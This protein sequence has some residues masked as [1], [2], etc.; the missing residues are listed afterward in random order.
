MSQNAHKGFTGYRRKK[1]TRFSVRIADLFARRLIA[2]G[3]VGTIAAVC[4]VCVFLIYVVLPLFETPEVDAASQQAMPEVETVR[5]LMVDEY[6]TMGVRLDAAGRVDLFRLDTGK[7]LDSRDISDGT[8]ATSWS[9]SVDGERLIFGYANGTIRLGEM[10]FIA[11][12]LPEDQ[13]PSTAKKLAPGEVAAGPEGSLITLTPGGYRKHSFRLSLEEPISVSDSAIVAVD[14][15]VGSSGVIFAAL[16]S[17][18][19]VFVKS[20]RRFE[21]LMT[22]EVQTELSGGEFDVQE[23]EA[24]GAPGYL[25]LSGA[26]D[27]VY[28]AWQNGRLHRYDTR[29]LDAPQLAEKIDLLAEPGRTVTNLR[30][31]LGRSTMLVGDSAGDLHAFFRI[32][33]EQS[34]AIPDG[35][36]MVRAHHVPGSGAA[37]SSLACSP[38]TRLAMVGYADGQAALLHVTTNQVLT[39]VTAGSGLPVTSM[40]IAPKENALYASCGDRLWG[41][42][43]DVKHPEA[44]LASMFSPIWYEGMPGPE[45]IWQ[46]SSGDDAF[47]PKL[48]LMPLVFG[49]LKATVYSMLFGVPLALLAAVYSSEFMHPR[50]RGRVKPTIELMAS[51]PSVVLGFL[52]ALVIAPFV[53]AIVPTVLAAIF[54]VPFVLLLGARFWQ[55]IPAKSAITMG[56]WRFVFVLAAL[57]A[58]VGLAT[59][60]GPWTERWLFAGDIK[61]WLD[62][63]R[64]SGVSGWL[65]FTLPISAL[66]IGILNTVTINPFLRSSLG[67]LERT[68]TALVDLAKYLLSTAAVILLAAALAWA[69]NTFAW[70][71]RGG[72]SFLG[73][74][75]QRNALVVGFIMGFAIIPIIYTIAEDALSTVP[76]HLRA[77]SLGAGATPWQTAIRIIVPTAMSGL[78]SAVMIGLGR[79]VGETM[80][81]LMAG[82]NTPVMEWNLFNGIR[83]LSANI[84]VELPEAPQNGTHYRTLFLAALVLFAL[85]FIVNTVAELVR[86]RFRKR[87]YQL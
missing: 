9:F 29:E 52:A 70:D 5:S 33:D 25:L 7:A 87:A 66:G 54:C 42:S 30:W 37:V 11:K 14:R 62:G 19:R 21:N 77:G 26:G 67:H 12:L 50:Q 73:T 53:E 31:L 46:S 44:T 13:V 40:A 4:L 24:P 47:E 38:R 81:V 43:L 22:G 83:T 63:Q 51:L 34:K 71:P 80:I 41:W 8:Q 64:G 45:H 3:G 39:R 76:E 6:R 79:A 23:A 72:A 74:Y 69:F 35:W 17:K 36:R 59:R 61:L 48:G 85:T 32:R 16:D 20:V 68:T 86:L 56:R 60:V 28:L 84:A 2:L 49:T 10:A 75:V 82:G 65:L 15:T 18:W 57:A 78:F 58:G 1:K 55:L 27:C